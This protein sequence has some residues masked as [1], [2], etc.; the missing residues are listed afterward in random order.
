MVAME[1]VVSSKKVRGPSMV[2]TVVVLARP[3]A[4]ALREFLRPPD[5]LGVQEERG[6]RDH[7]VQGSRYLGEKTKV[8]K[9]EAAH[10]RSL[11]S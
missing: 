7:L 3:Q 6:L 1:V 11:K 2:V 10:T 9:R 8:K 4:L 5:S